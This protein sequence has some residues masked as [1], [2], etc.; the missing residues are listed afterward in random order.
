MH[1]HDGHVL[2][3][4]RELVVAIDCRSRRLRAICRFFSG[5][6]SGGL[7]PSDATS[8]PAAPAA[9]FGRLG[10]CL[11]GGMARGDWGAREAD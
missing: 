11:E 3:G 6:S 2:K 9:F 7:S 4:S 1:C 5:F 8:R 10:L